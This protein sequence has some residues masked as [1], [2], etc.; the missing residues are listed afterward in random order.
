VSRG[1][2]LISLKVFLVALFL[3][4]LPTLA[5]AQSGLTLHFGTLPVVQSLPL[6]V[7]AEKGFFRERGLSVDL[8]LFNS[9]TEKDVAL[10]SGQLAGYFGDLMTPMVL[11]ANGIPVKM[12]ATLFSTP[13]QQPMFAIMAGPK[14][15]GKTLA[16]L[17]KAGLAGSSNT[18]IEYIALKIL[19]SQNLSANQLN[20]IEVK[21]ISIR[22]QMLLTDQVP[23]AILPEPLVSHAA[24]Q[25]ARA[26]AD[27]AGK[28]ISATVLAFADPFLKKHPQTV[29]T[30]LE[31]VSLASAF[32]NKNPA[33]V[34]PIM[35]QHCRIPD[36]LHQ[37]FA[38]PFFPKL[39][40]PEPDQVT[41]V[42]RWLRSKGIVQREMN[43]RQM[44][45]D[46]TLP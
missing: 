26:V 31:A 17:A 4:L 16:E 6:F 8:V 1:T 39:T 19:Q 36:P 7:A 24:A 38:V 25:G 35:N 27:D 11:N 46:G 5:A 9:A 33:E 10:T 44:V 30:F 40:L 21:N 45:A 29:K 18:I 12:A 37:K 2:R 20:M 34:R 13:P 28:G 14:S 3:A 42:Y 22:L 43:Y 32:I 15:R 23:G 41:D